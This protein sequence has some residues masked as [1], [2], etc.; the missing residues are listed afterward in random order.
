MNSGDT[1]SRDFG[2][3]L[4]KDFWG[5]GIAS[6]AAAAVVERL[7][8]AGYDYITATHDVNNPKSGE[9]M[10]RI[11][12]KYCYSYV[13]QWQPK[14]IPVTFRMY[15]LN[16]DGSNERVYMDYWHTYPEHFIETI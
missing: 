1:D 3:G 4:R 12:M 15:Q 8:N 14:N 13:E 6:E 7:K 2:Y 11:G 10:K 9:V 5:K 16:F